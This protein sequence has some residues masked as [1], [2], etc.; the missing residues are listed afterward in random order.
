MSTSLGSRLVKKG[1]VTSTV[2][3]AAG[4]PCGLFGH[5]LLGVTAL[6]FR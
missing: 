5:R 3:K 6:C 4:A 1:S 2:A